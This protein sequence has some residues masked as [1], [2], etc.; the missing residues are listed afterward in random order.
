V[1]EVKMSCEGAIVNSYTAYAFSHFLEANEQLPTGAG[2]QGVIS[3]FEMNKPK[4]WLKVTSILFSGA[5]KGRLVG[6]GK[7]RIKQ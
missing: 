4:I 6:P 2:P 1:K 5:A 7:R 3:G